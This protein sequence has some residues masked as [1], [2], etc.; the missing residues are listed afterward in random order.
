MSQGVRAYHQN[1]PSI[2]DNSTPL[3]SMYNERAKEHDKNMIENWK[4]D[5]EG[6]LVFTG[7]LSA[8]V[9]QLLVGSLQNLQPDPQSASTFYLSRIYQLTPGSNPSSIPLPDDPSTFRHL[10]PLSWSAHSGPSALSLV[11]SLNC[12]LLAMLLQQSARRYMRITQK[13]NDPQKRAQIRHLMQ[14]A[15]N[16]GVDLRW[17]VEI[18]PALLHTAVLLFLAGFV[19]YL[20]DINHFVAKFVSA[21]AG[22]GWL[23]YLYI[24]LAPI[25]SHDSP[26]YTPL[27]TLFWVIP[28]GIMSLLLQLHHFVASRW[29]HLGDT[30]RIRE[31][32]QFYYQ[33]A[34]RGP[35]RDMEEL[36]DARSSDLS[37]SILLST[38]NSLDGDSDV[39]QFLSA[40]PGFYAS[41]R[42]RPRLTG[43]DFEWFNSEQLPSKIIP[44]MDHVLSS[45]LLSDSEK[46]NYIG[47]CS[48]A[49]NADPLLLQSVLRQTLRTQNP[50]TS[51]HDIVRHTGFVRL[52]LE[53]LSGDYHPGT[54]VKDYAQCIVAIAISRTHHSDDSAWIDIARRYL[55][56]Q[57]SQYQRQGH[58]LRLCNLIYLTR[59]LKAS[60]SE[61]SDQFEDGGYWYIALV[62]ARKLEVRGTAR[63]LQEE[64]YTLLQELDV[65]ANDL[66]RGGQAQQNARK[67][68]SLLH[69]VRVS[70][71]I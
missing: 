38:F 31:S 39:D 18:L 56:P 48:R 64:F 32:F 22:I 66:Q 46:H 65:V 10:S 57:H 8:V 25:Y 28:M 42:T 21:C 20:F 15:L 62:E 55:E 12:A 6:A 19:I 52:A 5:V 27:T 67:I 17:V 40:I 58:N 36:A 11:I 37:T 70:L 2:L 53:Q 61:Q 33:R 69:T 54:L 60:Q 71:S 7:L 49:I 44:Y 45:D 14:Q 51:G 23:L 50:E 24:S 35:I 4:G 30:S 34:L 29:P 3:F 1:E 43:Q 16:K 41:T 68:L 47:I 59:Q 13:W 63:E 26:C 9:A